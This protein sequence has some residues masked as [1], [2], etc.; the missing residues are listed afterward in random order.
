MA[1]RSAAR[2]GAELVTPEHPHWPTRMNDLGNSAP[3]AL[4][5]RG[6]TELLID[7][8]SSAI[9]GRRP[10]T[11]S[12]SRWKSRRDSSNGAT[13][14]FQVP[15]TVSTGWRTVP[16]SHPA[17]A[18]SPTLL[19]ESIGSTRAVTTHYCHD[20]SARGRGSSSP[21][22]CRRRRFRRCRRR[23][24]HEAG[25]DDSPSTI[26]RNGCGGCRTSP[27]APS[28]S[29]QRRV[30][31]RDSDQLRRPRVDPDRQL[32]GRAAR[33]GLVASVVVEVLRVVLVLAV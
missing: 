8:V 17:A 5:V 32:T 16:P 1:F 10:D 22:R 23:I 30:L 14:S 6:N 21:T 27:R 29:S 31:A 28:R 7:E 3:V 9:V 19:G 33:S 4:W 26:P 11:V 2:F 18:P 24:A 12:T 25:V 15:P 13:R 20:Q